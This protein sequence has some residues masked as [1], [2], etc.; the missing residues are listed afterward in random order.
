MILQL[1]SQQKS[2]SNYISTITETMDSFEVSSNI[3]QEIVSSL[4][5]VRKEITQIASGI[6]SGDARERTAEGINDV[7]EQVVTLANTQNLGQYIFGGG[8]TTNA[9]YQVERTDGR[10][11]SVTY[12]GSLEH[13]NVEVADGMK[14]NSLLVGEEV[15]HSDNRQGC[16]FYGETGAQEGSGTS[17]V[18]GDVWLTVTGTPGNWSLS[19]DGGLTTYTSDG[20]NDNLAVVDSTT[21]Q[22][23]YVDTTQISETGTD[24]VRTP[25]TYDLFGM[26]ISIRDILKNEAN[27][28]DAQIKELQNTTVSS[29]EEISNLLVEKEV[30]IGSKIGFLEDLKNSLTDIKY[31]A[32]DESTGL[33]EADIAQISVDL[34]RREVLYQMSLSIA[35]KAL[36]V[37]LLDY[38][39]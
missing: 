21:G 15:F 12:Q 22:V 26:L 7:L 10:I 14:M 4:S 24:L 19:I 31:N 30:L 8:N 37:S 38:I 1:E 29:L 20:T 9:P 13:R 17:S 28:S 18:Q 33:Q 27:L 39:G 3:V 36:S 34:T 16:V 25:G 5:D 11:T 35:G 32:E 2:L 23:L 6:Y